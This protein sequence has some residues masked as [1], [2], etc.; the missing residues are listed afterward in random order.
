[1]G[2]LSKIFGGGEKQAPVQPV[3]EEVP[4]EPEP[5]QTDPVDPNEEEKR[6]VA[7]TN[8]KAMLAR[9]GRSSLVSSRRD[10][11]GIRGGVSIAGGKT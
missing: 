11:E 6:V 7:S 9:R 2:F 4:E 8:R 1:M 5:L 10:D 3:V